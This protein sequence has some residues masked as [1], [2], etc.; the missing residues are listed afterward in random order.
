MTPLTE[1][2]NFYVVVGS[3]AGALIGLQFV[4]IALISGLIRT[5]TLAQ[6][7]QAFS[8]PA[9]VHMTAV[10]FLAAALCAPWHTILPL[11]VLV[12]STGLAGVVYG[13]VVTLRLKRLAL[14]RPEFEDWL[15]HAVLPLVAYSALVASAFAA[16]WQLCRSLFCIAAAM[17][18]LLLISIHNAWDS[19]TFH[20]FTR[21]PEQK[22]R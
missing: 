2:Q 15:F 11:A 17:L 18:L 9:I 13:I 6:G 22:D 7:G 16:R 14:Y 19:V 4:V 3:S 8:T 21:E 5:G 12:G 10:L 1:W 20:L